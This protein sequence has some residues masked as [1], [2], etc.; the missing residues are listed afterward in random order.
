MR[1]MPQLR[2]V[3]F[4]LSAWTKAWPS[5]IFGHTIWRGD[6][7]ITPSART[8]GRQVTCRFIIDFRYGFL[9]VIKYPYQAFFIIAVGAAESYRTGAYCDSCNKHI[10]AGALQFHCTDC[11]QLDLCGPCYLE[12]KVHRHHLFV[13][14]PSTRDEVDA[15]LR[16]AVRA[17]RGKLLQELLQILKV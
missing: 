4:M 6:P 14:A 11:W 10:R 15:D 1:I 3:H 17:L 8:A 9:R 13:L 5:C 16:K 7:K 2:L 12:K